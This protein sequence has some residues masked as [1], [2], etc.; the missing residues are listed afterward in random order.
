M[1]KLTLLFPIAIL[2]F[3]SSCS[4]ETADTTI[5]DAIEIVENVEETYTSSNEIF[6]SEDNSFQIQFPVS[7]ERSVEVVPTEIGDIELVTYMYEQSLTKVYMVAYS[8]YPSL[9]V[10]MSNDEDLLIGGKEGALGSLGIYTL[11]EE[12]DL[13]MDGNKGMYFKGKNT[14]NFHVEYEM[15]MNGNRLYQIAI[16]ED[17][18]YPSEPEDKA[19]FET[20]EFLD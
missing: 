11:D 13:E 16:M 12:K 18:S 17:G 19:F 8:E 14:D 1:K 15:Y 9:L 4:G 20:F 2:L 5:E 3:L 10:Q 6:V 7:P